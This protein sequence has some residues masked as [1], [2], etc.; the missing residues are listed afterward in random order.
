MEGQLKARKRPPR[1]HVRVAVSDEIWEVFC[2]RVLR[3]HPDALRFRQLVLPDLT[4]DATGGVLLGMLN[5]ATTK[6]V[7]ASSLADGWEVSWGTEYSTHGHDALAEAA[8]LAWLA[9]NA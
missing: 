8:A 6:A 2:A 7:H 9:V 1:T 3:A 4:D 5:A